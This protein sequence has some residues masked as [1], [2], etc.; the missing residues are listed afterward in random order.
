MNTILIIK[1]ENLTHLPSFVKWVTFFTKN[2]GCFTYYYE[3]NNPATL[4]QIEGIALDYP[5]DNYKYCIIIGDQE[6]FSLLEKKQHVFDKKYIRFKKVPI[7]R[8]INIK[9]AKNKEFIYI[10][11]GSKW[12]NPYTHLSG[13][14]NRNE[15]I[16]AFNYDFYNSLFVR[17]NLKEI[18]QELRGCTLGCSCKP[19][20]CHG[21]T[22]AREANNFPF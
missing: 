2:L 11:R 22:L 16:N 6:T 7:T 8:V 15:A 13:E 20:N 1:D 17:A 3:H 18:I 10:G 19:L 21:D 14:M 5:L 9:T 4:N 12:G